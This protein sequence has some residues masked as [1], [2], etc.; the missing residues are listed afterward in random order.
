MRPLLALAA[1]LVALPACVAPAP[2][3]KVV[4]PLA[5]NSR[6]AVL[7][8]QRDR[9]IEMIGA[10]LRKSPKVREWARKRLERP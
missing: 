10:H 6:T 5:E 4:G 7:E 1:L 3:G 2:M 8:I 9:L